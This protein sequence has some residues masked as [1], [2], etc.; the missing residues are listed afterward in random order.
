[1]SDAASSQSL[2]SDIAFIRSMVEAGRGSP[3][4]GGV[5]LAAGLI[6]GTTSL[7][8]WIVWSGLW[9]APAAFQDLGF[10][11]FVAAIAFIAV[12]ALLGMFRRRPDTNRVAAAAWGAVGL[13]C[14]AICAVV[15]IIGGRSHQW[16][17]FTIL[18]PVIM[19][20]YGGG[21]MVGA[22]A[23]RAPWQRWIGALC[24]LSCLALAF[25]AGQPIQYLIY[26]LSLYG[27]LGLPGLLAVVRPHQTA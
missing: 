18:P 20:L 9:T 16:I 6:W 3:Y 15:I 14:L 22:V 13:V 19:A 24:L 26:A 21:W 11:W 5:S 25:T 23:F 2:S 27:L 4:R 7:Y 1:M 12:G 10:P 17:V 8:C